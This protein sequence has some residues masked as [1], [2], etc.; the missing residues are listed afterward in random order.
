M[1]D[2][3]FAP[4]LRE[5]ANGV[6]A[7][8]PARPAESVAAQV[9]LVVRMKQVQDDQRLL[10]VIHDSTISENIRWYWLLT[11]GLGRWFHERQVCD[12]DPV[13]PHCQ[14]RRWWWTEEGAI[15]S[16]TC[17]PP[18]PDWVEAWRRL[19]ALTS[20]YLHQDEQTPVV[21]GLLETADHA[22]RSNEWPTFQRVIARIRLIQP[23][24]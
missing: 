11:K 1:S 16:G 4:W 12:W 17:H 2:L 14:A 6:S 9:G 18:T 20:G 22:Y 21:L 5:S 15:D 10:G 8:R 19:A 3:R 24:P 13:C 7:D 23:S